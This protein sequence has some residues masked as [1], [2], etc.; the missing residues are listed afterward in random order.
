MP[1]VPRA[2]LGAPC[3]HDGRRRGASQYAT[4]L[5][6]TLHPT[7]TTPHVFRLPSHVWECM[8]AAGL[9]GRVNGMV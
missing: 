9:S 2:F 5:K 8:R 3:V 6:S 7:H 1:Q 4:G